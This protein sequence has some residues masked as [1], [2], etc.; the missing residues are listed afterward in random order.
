[1]TI[2]LEVPENLLLFLAGYNLTPE[3]GAV[4]VIASS[5]YRERRL[6]TKELQSLLG[7]DM[8]QLHGFLK[9]HVIPLRDDVARD[10]SPTPE[11][12]G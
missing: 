6:S 7:L 8:P 2:T 12:D 11:K 5:L 4:A 1:M 9:E 10:P 3:R